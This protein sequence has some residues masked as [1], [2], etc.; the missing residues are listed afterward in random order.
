MKRLLVLVLALEV[1]QLKMSEDFSK[2][3]FDYV[4]ERQKLYIDRLAEAVGYENKRQKCSS[5]PLSDEEIVNGIFLF[6]FDAQRYCTGFPP[7]RRS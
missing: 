5:V 2:K 3:F 7:Y 4:D 6:F 1:L